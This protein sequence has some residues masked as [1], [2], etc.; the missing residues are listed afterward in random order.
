MNVN[1]AVKVVRALLVMDFGHDDVDRV[2]DRILLN[3]ERRHFTFYLSS[4]VQHVALIAG[5]NL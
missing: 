5:V 3:H 2:S 1:A 4:L